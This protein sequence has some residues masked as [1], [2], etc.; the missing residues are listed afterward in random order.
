MSIFAIKFWCDIAV[1]VVLKDISKMYNS[2]N[3]VLCLYIQIC[4]FEDNNLEK[5][6]ADIKNY[7]WYILCLEEKDRW[8]EAAM[9]ISGWEER[10][11]KNEREEYIGWE[12]E[13]EGGGN[14]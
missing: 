4:F 3:S 10:E 11:W 2:F 6:H 12:T 1:H 7:F 5:F 13:S 14:R 9:K 8:E